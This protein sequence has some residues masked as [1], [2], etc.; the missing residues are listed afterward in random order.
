MDLGA[1]PGSWSQY[2]VKKVADPG[3]IIAVDLLPME[4]ISGV[5]FI[6]GDFTDP[7][8]VNQIISELEGHSLNLVLSDMAPNITGIRATDQARIEVL[9]EAILGFCE[10][11]LEAGG[12][13]LTKLFEGETAVQMRKNTK[14]LFKEMQILKPDASR[15][16]SK[17]IF[18]LASGYRHGKD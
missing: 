5:H 4:T 12:S 10:I 2:A 7:D 11:A 9:Q 18:L 8:V 1:A 15:S 17:E 16:E 14:N 6:Q 3:Q 13:L